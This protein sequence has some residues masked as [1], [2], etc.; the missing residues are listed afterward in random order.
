MLG[1]EKSHRRKPFR[2]PDYD[3]SSGGGYFIPIVTHKRIPVFGTVIDDRVLLFEKG[4]IARYE[5]FHTAQLR[6]NVELSR[7]NLSSCRTTFTTLSGKGSDI[8][9]GREINI[10]KRRVT[11]CRS[12]G[13]VM[14][15]LL[16][17]R[18]KR[19][20]LDPNYF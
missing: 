7:M 3:Y 1:E 18:V 4:R 5:W 19:K 6:K 20:V 2:L 15:Q 8:H 11:T 13:R 12:R 14:L 9:R 10:H 16:R 17:T